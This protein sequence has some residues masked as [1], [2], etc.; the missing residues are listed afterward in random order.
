MTLDQILED[1]HL[2]YLIG[3]T[4]EEVL[5]ELEAVQHRSALARAVIDL[6]RNGEFDAEDQT[7]GPA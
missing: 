5:A 1:H 6:V 3:G 4:R 2:H 7:A